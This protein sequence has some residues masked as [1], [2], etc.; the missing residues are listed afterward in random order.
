MHY[1]ETA[2]CCLQMN[3]VNS[4]DGRS[5]ISW[6]YIHVT[7]ANTVDMPELPLPFYDFFNR[8]LLIIIAYRF[9]LIENITFY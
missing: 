7:R 9:V 2:T 4:T 6:I 5:A 1:R 8:D 3:S